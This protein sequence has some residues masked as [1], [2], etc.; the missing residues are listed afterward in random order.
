M[1]ETRMPPAQSANLVA[2]NGSTIYGVSVIKTSRLKHG[3][4]QFHTIFSLKFRNFNL[5]LQIYLSFSIS[6]TITSSLYQVVFNFNSSS[7]KF[8]LIVMIL[9]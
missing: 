7:N 8:Q 2:N 1:K 6:I 5:Q 4:D 3:W 9:S